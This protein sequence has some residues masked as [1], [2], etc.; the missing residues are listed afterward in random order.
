MKLHQ[1][2]EHWDKNPSDS[3]STETLYPYKRSLLTYFEDYFCCE[4]VLMVTDVFNAAQYAIIV[5]SNEFSDALE[6]YLEEC[7][8]DEEEKEHEHKWSLVDNEDLWAVREDVT[9]EE[10][11]DWMI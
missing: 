1:I 8:L 3:I 11:E 4:P 2:I 9:E 7:D 6:A 10:L 5:P